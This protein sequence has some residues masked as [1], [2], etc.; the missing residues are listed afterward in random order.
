MEMPQSRRK[1]PRKAPLHGLT[2]DV[3]GPAGW[4]F[5]HAITF[6][7]PIEPTEMECI[8]MALF[9]SSMSYLLP[10]PDCCKHFQAELAK[11]DICPECP[12]VTGGRKI[13]GPWLVKV[14][15]DINRRLGKPHF[16]LKEAEEIY[17]PIDREC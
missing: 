9:L 12:I 10:C 16:P 4:T 7:F 14:H 13:L 6:E 8:D 5:L 1:R 15:N 17:K 2:P 3:W 11:Y